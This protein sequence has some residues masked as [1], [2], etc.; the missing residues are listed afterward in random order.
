MFITKSLGRI[1]IKYCLHFRDPIFELSMLK[2]CVR[3]F[4]S[5]GDIRALFKMD[6]VSS[7]TGIRRGRM[8][9]VGDFKLHVLDLIL[10]HGRHDA[11]GQFTFQNLECLPGCMN[12]CTVTIM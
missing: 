5:T 1:R 4:F 8:V 6:Y 11:P 7:E 9:I 12:K 3:I 2:T 10:S